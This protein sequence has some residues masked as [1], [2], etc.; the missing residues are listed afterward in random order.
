MLTKG[1]RSLI[2]DGNADLALHTRT[3]C[4]DT[5][6][7]DLTNGVEQATGRRVVAFRSASHIDPDVR[8]GG[9]RRRRAACGHPC[10]GTAVPPGPLRSTYDVAIAFTAGD[11]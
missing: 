11:S 4:Q 3:A 6:G 7:N 1:E 9:A 10:G 2:R 5:M 8:N